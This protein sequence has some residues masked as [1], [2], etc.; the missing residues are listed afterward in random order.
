MDNI[1]KLVNFVENGGRLIKGEEPKYGQPFYGDYMKQYI[2]AHYN[3][4]DKVKVTT[5]RQDYE[6]MILN[7][8]FRFS[9]LVSGRKV[10]KDKRNKKDIV[11]G[12]IQSIELIKEKDDSFD[13]AIVDPDEWKWKNKKADNRICSHEKTESRKHMRSKDCEE[14]HKVYPDVDFD[15]SHIIKVSDGCRLYWPFNHNGITAEVFMVR[16]KDKITPIPCKTGTPF[17]NKN[18]YH[19]YN[20]KLKDSY[21]ELYLYLPDNGFCYEDV[22]IVCVW[23]I[24]TPVGSE[25]SVIKV[26]NIH[27]VGKIKPVKD[28]YNMI[29]IDMSVCPLLGYGD[30]LFSETRNADLLTRMMDRDLYI[31]FELKNDVG[32]V[33]KSP[34]DLEED[35]MDKYFAMCTLAVGNYNLQEVVNRIICSQEECSPLVEVFC[36]IDSEPE[37]Y[38]SSSWRHCR[39]GFAF[40]ML[41]TNCN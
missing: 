3:L 5:D 4:G 25:N 7:I 10:H 20:C 28:E 27:H 37:R 39:K 34:E 2:L 18:S 12:D 8:G 29:F 38:Y 26:V 36:D 15:R 31:V 19:A 17:P 1:E 14:F 40:K 6:G 9:L 16:D 33:I 32:L 30:S 41:S 24:N 22:N 11:Y 23:A 13:L 35:E 21:P